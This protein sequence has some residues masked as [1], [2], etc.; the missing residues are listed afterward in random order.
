MDDTDLQRR[1]AKIAVDTWHGPLAGT[2]ASR[3]TML[4]AFAA[5]HAAGWSDRGARDVEP[6]DGT[7]VMVRGD[8]KFED[9]EAPAAY[10]YWLYQRRDDWIGHTSTASEPGAHWYKLIPV[11]IRADRVWTWAQLRR[12]GEVVEMIEGDLTWPSST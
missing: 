8:A 10:G 3:Q 11:N 1:A 7:V 12:Q 6:A 5:G 9:P 4:D 2:V